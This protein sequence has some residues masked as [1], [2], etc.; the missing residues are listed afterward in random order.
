MAPFR[1]RLARVLEW[2]RKQS[3]IEEERLRLCTEQAIQAIAAVERHQRDV[4]A[5]Q[6][7]LIQSPEPQT[8]ELA[9]LEPFRRR[10]K[11]HEAQLIR[12]CH[13]S[14]QEADLQR[15]VAQAAQRRLRL[16]EKL[17][18]RRLSEHSYEADREL[19]EL[20]TETHLAGFARNLSGKPTA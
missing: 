10:A 5:R 2:Y 7:E 17:R 1:F 11:Q 6:M 19:E 15:G 14:T 12:K 18:D 13:S 4:L 9:A 8:H 16:V 20:A 3:Q